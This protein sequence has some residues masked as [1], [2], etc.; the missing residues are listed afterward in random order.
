[1]INANHS[2]VYLV[3]K[4][5]ALLVMIYHKDAQLVQ[6]ATGVKYSVAIHVY[7]AQFSMLTQLNVCLLS[8]QLSRI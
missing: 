6:L 1:V 8:V 3:I 4:N 5:F 7:R 2:L